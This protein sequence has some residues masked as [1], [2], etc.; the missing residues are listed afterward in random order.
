MKFFTRLYPKTIT[1]QTL[2]IM[3]FV[4][5]VAQLINLA[6]LVGEHRLR[7]KAN[8]VESASENVARTL[9][10][11]PNLDRIQIPFE[12]RRREI[13]D[14]RAFI[15]TTSRA[16]L[17]DTDLRLI[18]YESKAKQTLEKYG[19][20]HESLQL[21][22]V[23]ANSRYS[24]ELQKQEAQDVRRPPRKSFRGPRGK[25]PP[26]KARKPS[27]NPS[28]AH[29]MVSI[30]LGANRWFN[31]IIP[32]PPMEALTPRI[33][34]ATTTLFIITLVSLMFFMR[35]ITRPLS[36]FTE[37]ADEFGRG[38][39][40]S[41]L[42][43]DGPADI[44]QAAQ[45]FN[46]MQR[47]LTRTIETQNTMLRAVGHDLRTPL[48]SLRI[49]SEMIPDN[50]QREKFI[51]TINDMSLMTEEILSWSKNTSSIEPLAQVDI[52]AL[53]TSIV[54][55]FSDQGH[56]VVLCTN[57]GVI[58]NIRRLSLKRAIT[59]VIGNALKY[60]GMARVSYHIADDR[61]SIFIEDDGPGIPEEK[62]D[63]AIK[64]FVRL[65]PSRNKKTGGTGLGL[66]I[67]ETILHTDGGKLVIENKRPTGLRVTLSLPV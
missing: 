4:L 6:I 39:E 47:R 7:A 64:P 19:I 66:S 67:T 2:A 52:H 63:D 25:G 29:L 1:S 14:G 41:Q 48:T 12:L 37:A 34:A 56:N 35:R 15:S 49:R 43:E 11:I 51:A 45:A 26:P 65:E 30:Q 61:F 42:S 28:E 50:D 53:L 24:Y 31:A 32:H 36:K 17:I 27:V 55:D 40:P 23:P 22:L 58:L 38:Q 59:N 62:I 16:N 21:T 8:L 33:L 5:L 46:R 54:S 10:R 13:G 3:S 20:R 60:A 9:S 18:S 57:S 44:R